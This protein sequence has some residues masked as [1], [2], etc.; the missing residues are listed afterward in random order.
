M[1]W[2]SFRFIIIL[3]TLWFLNY[4]HLGGQDFDERIMKYVIE[5]IKKLNNYNMLQQPILMKRLRRACK[6]AKESLSFKVESG[7]VKVRNISSINSE[8]KFIFCSWILMVI[9]AWMWKFRDLTSTNS[10]KIYSI[11]RWKW[12]KRLYELH[13][14]QQNKL[15]IW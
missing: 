4:N 1:W 7:Y 12:L 13:K 8:M 2:C 10:A 15:I 9:Q 3:L 6:K 5:E 14:F 11:K